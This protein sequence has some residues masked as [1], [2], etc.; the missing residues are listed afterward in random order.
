[1]RAAAD[2]VLV[3]LHD[4]V[5]E[6]V[7]PVAELAA[8]DLPAGAYTFRTGR[9]GRSRRGKRAPRHQ[10]PRVDDRRQPRGPRSSRR[11]PGCR[12]DGERPGAGRRAGATWGRCADQRPPCD[13]ARA[14]F[15]FV[16]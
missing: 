10:P 12:V 2:G 5:I 14:P 7:G 13:A 4:R 1:M 6:G 8:G 15:R 3:V 9:S 16:Q 11:T